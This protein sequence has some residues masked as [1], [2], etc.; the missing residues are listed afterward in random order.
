M[1]SRLIGFLLLIGWLYTIAVFLVPDIAD[2]YGNPEIN[3]KVRSFKD[4][5]LL[6]ASGSSSAT[7][8]V[9]KLTTETQ[10]TIQE[11]TRTIK[12]IQTTVEQKTK[13][14]QDTADSVKT[15]IDAVEKA[16]DNINTLTNLSGTTQK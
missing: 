8:I 9:D 12:Q 16:K 15:A 10:K 11:G 1:F 4:N 3:A 5:S 2:K 7:S 13:Q 14:V 6:M